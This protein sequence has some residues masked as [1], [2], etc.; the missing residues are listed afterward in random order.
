[1]NIES[2]VLILILSFSICFG[3]YS[4]LT[5]RRRQDAID[6]EEKEFEEDYYTETEEE[7][8]KAKANEIWETRKEKKKL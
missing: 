4:L 6:K 3:A 5:S 7:V 1:M 2:I 8:R